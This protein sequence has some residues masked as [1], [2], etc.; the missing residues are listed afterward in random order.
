MSLLVLYLFSYV[1]RLFIYTFH[2]NVI[3]SSLD[4]TPLPDILSFALHL[5]SSPFQFPTRAFSLYR[6]IL[7]QHIL[8]QFPY[9]FVFPLVSNSSSHDFFLLC[10]FLL[11]IT[12]FSFFPFYFISLL[13]SPSLLAFFLHHTSFLISILLF[14]F[15]LF[16][17]LFFPLYFYPIIT[18]FVTF[19]LYL[20]LPF[21]HSP[22]FYI[23]FIKLHAA[24]SFYFSFVLF[25]ILL[26]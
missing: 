24:R 18:P 12:L 16:F 1:S 5:S 25:Y 23:I 7:L 17:P 2:L 22:C 14:L 9:P 19:S 6:S 8:Q 3:A 11:P 15:S 21:V 10:Y 4:L 26:C 13:S 20:I